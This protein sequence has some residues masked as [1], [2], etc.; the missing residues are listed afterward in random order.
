MAK[1][2]QQKQKQRMKKR[3][4]EKQRK[5][6]AASTASHS[7]PF[8]ALN[9]RKKILQ[10]RRLPIH[11]CLIS[12]GWKKEGIAQIVVSRQQPDG[13]ILFG[14]FLVDTYC[15]GVKNSFCNA[16]LTIGVYEEKFKSKIAEDMQMEKC[17]PELA[18]QVI[19]GAI[20]FAA[21]YGFHPDKDFQL[22]KNVLEPREAFG[23]A[24]NL[25]FGQE[26]KPLFVAGPRDNAAKIMA[27]LKEKA[28]E[29]NYN[30]IVPMGAEE[31]YEEDEEFDE[32]FAEE[33]EEKDL[34]EG[35]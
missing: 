17:S 12:T 33:D 6:A 16:D 35:R 20:D 21:K 34:P 14:A 2:E 30:Y 24:K 28:G 26:G 32:D 22:A 15:L 1:S 29:G 11:E 31:S 8:L 23:P 27:Q 25:E 5:K 9:P 4:K 19:Y 18:H 10:A 3:Q 7:Q 13:T